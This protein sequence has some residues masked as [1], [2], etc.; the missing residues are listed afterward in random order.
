MLS[1]L[2]KNFNRQHFWKYFSCFSHKIGFDISYK[3]SPCE[4]VCMK[5]QSL[6]S[7]KNEKNIINLLSA[8][9]VIV[10]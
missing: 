2:G 1:M 9:S 5:Y 6:F 8:E 3:L 4:T 7:G 10:C